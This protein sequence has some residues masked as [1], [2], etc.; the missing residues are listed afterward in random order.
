[1]NILLIAGESIPLQTLAHTDIA[2]KTFTL[3]VLTS[4]AFPAD[5]L[6]EGF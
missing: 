2:A 1:M 4:L 6:I 3:T 5:G